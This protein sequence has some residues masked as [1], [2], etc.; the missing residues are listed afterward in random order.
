MGKSIDYSKIKAMA[1]SILECIGEDSEGENPDLP[2]P[3]VKAD[4]TPSDFGVDENS[5]G[6]QSPNLDFIG[7]EE[8]TDKSES[9]KM[10][11]REGSGAE[12][13][14]RKKK[15]DASIAMYGASL[16]SKFGK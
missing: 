10:E 9:G 13:E 14:E 3:S 2:K 15:K 16:A 6:G 5:G 7:N 4:P 12:T 8:M 1:A 11:A